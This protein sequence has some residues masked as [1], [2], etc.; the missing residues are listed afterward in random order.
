MR[1]LSACLITVLV[2][3]AGCSGPQLEFSVSEGGVAKAPA[4]SNAQKRHF[5]G[6]VRSVRIESAQMEKRSDGWAEGDRC[7]DEQTEFNKD[8]KMTR[9]TLYSKKGKPTSECVWRYDARG[10]L[11]SED[12]YLGNGDLHQRHHHNYYVNGNMSEQLTFSS[13][14]RLLERE[15]FSYDDHGNMIGRGVYGP[16]GELVMVQTWQ[17]DS[18][19]RMIEEEERQPYGIGHRETY[20]YDADGRKTESRFHGPYGVPSE[21]VTHSYDDKGRTHAESTY[22]TEGNRMTELVYKDDLLTSHRLDSPEGVAKSTF[23]YDSNGETTERVFH[24]GDS[25]EFYYKWSAQREYDS[26]GNWIK[27]TSIG[28]GSPEAPDAKDPL[29]ET[30]RVIYRQIEYY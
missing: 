26:H 24:R 3:L 6:P 7:L 18:G 8:G 20:S 1:R 30:R 17:Y 10:K 13:D 29:K 23:A 22:D 5:R 28:L 27:E 11:L 19:N 25:K 12:Q 9:R 21:R 15:M 16:N 2:L 14:G 4:E